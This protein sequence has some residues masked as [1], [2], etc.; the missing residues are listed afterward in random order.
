METPREH[1]EKIRRN[2]FSIGADEANPLTEDLHQAVKNLS[3]EL[4]AKDVHFLM[5]LIQ[6][7]EDNEY[8]EGVDPSLQFVITAKDITGTGAASTLLIFN[9]EK[10]FSPKNI[11]SICS[12]GRSTK[13]NNRKRGYIG[14]KGIG[15]KSVF[16][17]TSQPH[18]FSNGYQICFNESPCSKCNV[19]YIVPEWVEENPILSEIKHIYGSSS[20]LP[21]TTILLPLKPDK[22]KPVKQQLSSI[23]PELL[24]FL[25]KI[26]RLSVREDTEDPR[27][28]TVTA[29][30]ISSERNF[31][32]RKNIDAESY[33]L[34]LSADESDG[35][36]DRECG[37]HMWRQRFPVRPENKVERRTEV[38]EYVITLAFPTGERLHRGST[39]PG[40]YAF[41]PTEMVTN[42]PFIIQ[43]DFLLASSRETI[44]LDC[45]W[46]QGILNWVP[47]AFVNA[48][49]SLVKEKEDA[50][51]F[52]LPQM[53]GFLPVMSSPYA[54]LNSVRASIQSK[55]MEESIIPC[56]SYTQQ[57]FFHKPG[58]VGRLMPAFWNL[59]KM[60]K[61]QGVCLYNI[62]THGKYIL[63]S[64]FDE[65][66]YDHILN[67]LGV[68]Y[69]NDDWYAKCVRS[70]N[71]VLGGS[72]DLYLELLLFIAENWRSFSNT[73]FVDIPLLK[74]VCAQSQVSL[75]R[76]NE[77][78]RHREILLSNKFEQISWLID[79]N[80]EF[81]CVNNRFFLAQ[82]TQCQIFSH[83]KGQ[84][85]WNWLMNDVKVSFVTVYDYALL[86]SK[87]LG[88]DRKCVVTYVHFLYHS[89]KKNYLSTKEVNCA[90]QSMPLVDNYGQ[91]T[92]SRKGVLVPANGSDWVQLIGSNPW[93]NEGY[94]ELGEDYLYSGNHAGVPTHEK[95]LLQFLESHVAASDIPNLPPPDAQIPSFSSLLTKQNAFLLL[96]WIHNLKEKGCH[97]PS[98]FLN[99]IKNGSWLRVS[100]GGS[101][102]CKPPSQSFLFTS[103]WGCLLQNGS[104]LV[105]IPLVDQSFYGKEISKYNEELRKVGVIS[106]FNEACEY[107]GNHLMSI[108]ASST[109]TRAHVFSILN[110]IRFLRGNTLPPDNFINRIKDKR[111]L[112][113]SQGDR[114]PLESVF[115]DEEWKAASQISDIPFIDRDYYGEEIIS[116]RSEL[117]LLGVVIG[118]S[119]NYKLIVNNFKSASCFTYLPAEAVLLMLECLHHFSLS[120][121][122]V[123]LLK[124]KLRFK[125]NVGYKSPAE[126]YLFDPTWGC[127]LQV[128]NSFPLV[129]ILFYGESI[130]S[131]RNELKRIG[132]LVDF[133]EATKAFARLFKQQASLSSINKDNVLSFLACCKKLKHT[134]FKFPLDLK[135]CILENKWLRTRLGDCKAP[136]ECILFSPEWLSIHSISRLPFID[137]SEKYY[138]KGIHEYKKEL[139]SM[140]VVV[141]FKYGAKFLASSLRLP[142]DPSSITAAAACSLLECIRNLQG[143]ENEPLIATLSQKA[144]REWIKTHVGYRSP[145]K[146]LLFGSDWGSTLSREDGPFID[147]TFYGPSISSYSEE[148]NALGV[149][150]EKKNGC[151][152]LANYLD[153]HT[154]FMAIK[155][156]YSYLNELNWKSTG[157]DAAKIWIPNGSNDGK[158]VSSD[159]CV[160]HDKDGLFGQQLT[161]LDK[162]YEKKLL[163]FFSS[164]LEV[165][166]FPSLDDYCN[167]WMDWEASGHLLSSDECI[168]F[169]GFVT[170]HWSLV[171]QKVLSENILKL[172]VLSG[173]ERISLVDKHD[174][175]IA[176]DLCL[177]DLFE[178]SA[179]QPLFVWYPQPSLQSLPRNKLL[180][181]YSK[182]GVRNLSESV[183][184]IKQSA[185]NDVAPS[186]V[187]SR[188]VFIE[189]GLF[190]LIL[191]FLADLQVEV[192]KRHDALKGLLEI[193]VL[194]TPTPITVEYSL[195]LTSGEIINVSARRMMRWEREKSVFF[196]Q[197]VD[198]SGG[199]KNVLEFATYF[200]EVIS[201]GLLWDKEDHIQQLAELIKLGFILEFDEAAIGFLMKTKNLQIF[202]EDE[203]F[204]SSSFSSC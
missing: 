182:I 76:I 59:L 179:S 53:F 176:D 165:K 15:F 108:A 186:Q 147:E 174:V 50:P 47:T 134:G 1:I 23:H 89:L 160:L 127:L 196:M 88:N 28:N 156:I 121:K 169:W 204:L 192:Q 37:Y 87:V 12:V 13:K 64:A 97:M 40:I 60:A 129:D 173:S 62:S 36:L 164:A 17:I 203:E 133:E 42:F 24:L 138:G 183:Q 30:S 137:D 54:L 10:G 178:Q 112:R 18:I 55:L 116:F 195:Q 77:V 123:R 48:F 72:E 29:I 119:G 68:E 45:N 120:D 92:T 167:L 181:I 132:V 113:T 166:K 80:G 201:E 117:Q 22:V 90:S 161:I 8:G 140:G 41:L 67:F 57:K 6:N 136:K 91:V 102:S 49:T 38:E 20:N 109:L 159:E 25:S 79:W 199:Y 191:G 158:W 171:T 153:T 126:C 33:L 58:E 188:E 95:E 73:S 19:G 198:K 46:N 150:V 35:N 44:L 151:L 7:A 177:K 107:I 202:L 63:S 34:H 189:R 2:K 32:T 175:F 185:F 106:E 27:S 144:A 75:C 61:Q 56:E 194:E 170:K 74:Y 110:F 114:S 155:R 3:A 31:V 99:S 180:D 168:A 96:Q 84:T 65:E 4:Y 154:N 39:S 118:F 146:C 86:L 103:S 130:L 197:K 11:E 125:T 163:D 16:L 66:K 43:A 128:F 105:D 21:T 141:S 52:L 82:F 111:W 152:L 93:R 83:S 70:S 98:K 148:L 100:L 14:E 81:L 5:E 145:D 131:F 143:E 142:Q 85:I 101:I 139:Q 149:V 94:V 51:D 135:K 187:N 193:S 162:Y 184:K 26:K 200:A 115:Y 78:S 172:P 122:L 157:E 104:V 124:D 69:V 190:K 9:N 71:L